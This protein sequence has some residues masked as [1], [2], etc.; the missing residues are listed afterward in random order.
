VWFDIP[1]A[2]AQ[3]SGVYAI[4]NLTDGKLYVGST[5]QF[6]RRS[7]QHLSSLRLVKHANAFLQASFNKHGE[8]SFA[9]TLLEVVEDPT[10]LVLVEQIHLDKHF[11]GK[12]NCYNISPTAS[13]VQGVVKS[14]ETVERHRQ[15]LARFYETHPGPRLGVE[16]SVETR[17]KLSRSHL[18]LSNHTTP[19]SDEAKRSI[20]EAKLGKPCKRQRYDVTLVGPDGQAHEHV[21]DVKNFA[22]NHGLNNDGLY[23]LLKGKY[24]EY[25]GWTN[26]T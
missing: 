10:Q 19:H 15:A 3:A 6:A 18:G 21:T 8:G 7:R 1:D 22:R 20:S 2:L 11:D 26:P 5:S 4:T 13:S 17:G 25:R 9:F 12:V 24:T 23:G 14:V 16:L